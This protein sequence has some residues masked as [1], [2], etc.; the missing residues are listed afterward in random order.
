MRRWLIVAVFLLS[1]TPAFALQTAVK[2]GT[3][4]GAGCVGP[5]SSLAPK[6]RACA[7]ADAQTRIWCPNGDIFDDANAKPNA[8]LA[9]SLC[10]MTQIP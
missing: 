2:K 3:K 1:G 7:T 6:L 8:P 4:I 9:R 10:N 5:V